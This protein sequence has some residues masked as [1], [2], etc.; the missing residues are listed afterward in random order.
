[1]LLTATIIFSSL[2][3]LIS[4]SAFDPEP[5]QRNVAFRRAVW[6]SSA[7]NYDNTAQLVTDGIIGVL[8]NEVIDTSGTSSSNPTYGQ[9]IPGTINSE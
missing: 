6:H 1:M 4:A 7:A 9:M 3:I 2:V 8:S 5:P